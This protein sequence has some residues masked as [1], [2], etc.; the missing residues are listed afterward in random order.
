MKTTV[1]ILRALC[2]S[3]LSQ[4]DGDRRSIVVFGWFQAQPNKNILTLGSDRNTSSENGHRV[5]EGI[6]FYFLPSR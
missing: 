5:T 3:L 1:Q 4:R 6:T 2:S